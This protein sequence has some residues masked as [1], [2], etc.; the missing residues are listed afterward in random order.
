MNEVFFLLVIKSKYETAKFQPVQ[1]KRSAKWKLILY[2]LYYPTTLYRK[3]S[4]T[5]YIKYWKYTNCHIYFMNNVTILFFV[6]IS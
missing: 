2:T 6:S 4:I 3:E 5:K 1:L